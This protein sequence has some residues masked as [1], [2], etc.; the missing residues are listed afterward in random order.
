MGMKYHVLVALLG[1][2]TSSAIRF[3]D[4]DDSKQIEQLS[5]TSMFKKEFNSPPIEDKPSVPENRAQIVAEDISDVVLRRIKKE[6][7]KDEESLVQ[8]EFRPNP[9]QAP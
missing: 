7:G 8:L 3:V 9:A 2:K 4:F 5:Q 1:L 6:G